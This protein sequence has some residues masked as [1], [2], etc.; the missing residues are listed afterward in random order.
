MH[1]QYFEAIVQLRNHPEFIVDIVNAFLKR[2][3]QKKTWI[4]K[5]VKSKN[6]VD[7]YFSSQHAAQRLG[8]VLKQHGAKIVVSQR[9]HSMNRQSSKLQYRVTI[10]A[11]FPDFAK[12]DVIAQEK[13]VIKITSLAR[14]LTGVDLKTGKKV[15]TEIEG[16]KLP[17]QEARISTIYPEITIFDPETYEQMPLHTQTKPKRGEKVKV[18]F[19]KGSYYRV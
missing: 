16:T 3:N 1:S 17:K 10:L 12:G 2:P 18:V 4:A 8:N 13:K 15:S 14:R 11:K 19:W 6:G 9:L 7:L 5:Q